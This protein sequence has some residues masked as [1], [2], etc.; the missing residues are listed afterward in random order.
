MDQT[1]DSQVDVIHCPRTSF[2][3]QDSGRL[4]SGRLRETFT[5]KKR[6]TAEGL[7]MYT[8]LSIFRDLKGN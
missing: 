6:R 8:M 4:A 5:Q 1:C 2:A 3:S 7:L